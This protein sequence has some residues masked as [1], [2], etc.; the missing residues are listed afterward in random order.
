MDRRTFLASSVGLLAAPLA[1]EAQ[2]AEKIPRVG[3]LTGQH[4]TDF[5][6]VPEVLQQGLRELGWVVDQNIA[7]EVRSAAGRYD[8]LLELATELVRLKVDVIVTIGV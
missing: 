2:P 5:T 7:M 6:R 3:Y 4:T 1:V 8:R